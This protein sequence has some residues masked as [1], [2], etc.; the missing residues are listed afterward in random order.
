[1]SNNI[2]PVHAE[3]PV[4]FGK[5]VKYINYNI[6]ATCDITKED[7]SIET[8]HFIDHLGR[9]TRLVISRDFTFNLDLKEDRHNYELLIKRLEQDPQLDSIIKVFDDNRDVDKMNE[10]FEMKLNVM[11]KITSLYQKKNFTKLASIYRILRG[12]AKGVATS[13]VYKHL[14]DEAEIR[15]EKVESIL[16][17]A[18]FE[19]KALIANAVEKDYLY[20]ED[21]FYKSQ[22][23]K[24]LANSEEQMVFYLEENQDVLA[25]IKSMVAVGESGA[26][27]PIKLPKQLEK[28]S[29]DEVVE[30]ED[31]ASI[32]QKMLEGGV[33]VETPDNQF[34]LTGRRVKYKD[35]DA[36]I[37]YFEN[38]PKEYTLAKGLLGLNNTFE[39]FV[40]P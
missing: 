16:E 37:E 34:K 25:H 26:K 32:I 11:N 21:G 38:N 20:I 3:V 7:G 17:D 35:I 24:V 27:S 8:R 1:M 10:A 40:K 18:D 5:G 19:V 2:I 9:P 30:I 12:S 14:I 23:G 22:S 36:L 28:E 15:P 29:T 39:D 33:V 31:T 6:D 13:V 4:P